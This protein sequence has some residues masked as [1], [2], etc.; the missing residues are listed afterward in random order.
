MLG[1]TCDRVLAEVS[2]RYSREYEGWRGA[3]TTMDSLVP[4]L[5]GD[6]VV[7]SGLGLCTG[8]SE[9]W[10]GGVARWRSSLST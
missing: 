1:G 2:G 10:G 6:M 7:A 8:A 3:R 9:G 4:A 5:G